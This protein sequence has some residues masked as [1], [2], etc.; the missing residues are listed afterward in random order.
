MTSVSIFNNDVK[1]IEKGIKKFNLL[2]YQIK[3]WIDMQNL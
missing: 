3:I 2:F 1:S